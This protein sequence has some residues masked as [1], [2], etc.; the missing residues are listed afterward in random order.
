MLISWRSDTTI[1]ST[2]MLHTCELF[3]SCRTIDVLTPRGYGNKPARPFLQRFGDR[4]SPR[5]SHRT[6]Y[7]LNPYIFHTDLDTT[8]KKTGEEDGGDFAKQERLEK[9]ASFQLMMIK[10]AMK[11]ECCSLPS[12]SHFPPRKLL[13]RAIPMPF[14]TCD[15]AV[16][17]F[18]WCGPP[19]QRRRPE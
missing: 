12:F 7:V 5:P 13:S 8:K 1:K 4:Q 9:L 6:R 3:S 14:P 11:C 16:L 19:Y 2:R 17:P 18:P 10:H 15:A